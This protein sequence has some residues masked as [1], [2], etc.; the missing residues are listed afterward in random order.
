M[1][2]L[3]K[4]FKRNDDKMKLHILSK[5]PESLNEIHTKVS[6]EL[7]M[8]DLEKIKTIIREVYERKQLGKKTNTVMH[9]KGGDPKWKF[10]G[11]CYN[12]GIK[13]HLARD[14]RK[15]AKKEVTCTKCKKK[16]HYQT[17]CKSSDEKEESPSQS[18][19]V[20][21]VVENGKS[22]SDESSKWL[23]DSGSTVHVTTSDDCLEQVRNE[24]SMPL[25]VANGVRV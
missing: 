23:L 3:N 15:K 9:V 22:K 14:C 11:T 6:G 4:E 20:G 12:C 8:Y 2:A 1:G 5:L 24:E 25:A 17:Q 18:M 10:K 13:G 19:F 16:G 7:N 21:N